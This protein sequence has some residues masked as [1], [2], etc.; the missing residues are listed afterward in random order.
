MN[1][2]QE[3]NILIV[4]G[5]SLI[6]RAL[7][8][9]LSHEVASVLRTS[10]RKQTRSNYLFL[11]L[12]DTTCTDTIPNNISLA[13]ICAAI[14]SIEECRTNPDK[15]HFI[16]VQ[17]IYEVSKKLSD[18]GAK[19]VF[20]SSNSV[21]DGSQPFREAETSPCPV[22]E[23]GKQK[24][25][26]EKRLLALGD[27]VTVVRLTKVLTD[28]TPIL[29]EWIRSLKSD[30]IIHPRRDMI[31]S[32]LSLDFVIDILARLTNTACSGI[33]QLSGTEDISYATVAQELARQLAV[34]PELVQPISKPKNVSIEKS[35]EFSTLDIGRLRDIFKAEPPGLREVVH[36]VLNNGYDKM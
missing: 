20:L 17:Q 9:R 32:P 1:K 29:R 31:L 14:T 22:S 12:Y 3:P 6:G 15:S 2:T 27:N 18:S 4:G 8:L 30:Q 19:I 5:D 11:D 23:Y 10:R 28:Q 36:A 7:A 33:L 21:Y 26:I 24:A 13:F 34:A 25:E 35:P 16:N